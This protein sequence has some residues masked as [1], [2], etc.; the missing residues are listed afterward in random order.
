MKKRNLITTAVA[1]MMSV[2][3]VS[4]ASDKE[5]MEEQRQEEQQKMEESYESAEHNVE[6]EMEET[7]DSSFFSDDS[8]VSDEVASADNSDKPWADQTIALDQVEK[9]QEQ[10]KSEGLYEGNVDGLIGPKTEE[11]I[12]KFQE[13]QNL[14]ASGELNQETIDAMGVDVDLKQAQESSEDTMM[15]E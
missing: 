14:T 2:G 7:E 13:N 11:G 10:L 4:C 6:Q 3:M 8:E 5:K 9:V 15:S 1:L 12:R